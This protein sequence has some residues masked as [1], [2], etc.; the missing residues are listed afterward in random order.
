MPDAYTGNARG[1]VLPSLVRLGG[2]LEIPSGGERTT[3]TPADHQQQ[4]RLTLTRVW[5]CW[6]LQNH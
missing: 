2:V 1:F 3:D 4:H 5:F 6:R